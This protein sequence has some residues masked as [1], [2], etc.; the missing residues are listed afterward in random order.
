[1]EVS[2]VSLL[3]KKAE[4]SR[5]KKTVTSCHKSALSKKISIKLFLPQKNNNSFGVLF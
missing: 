2:A 1:M 5:Q 3:E 4:S